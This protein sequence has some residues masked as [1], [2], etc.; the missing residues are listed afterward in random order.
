MQVAKS[1]DSLEAPSLS[2]DTYHYVPNIFLLSKKMTNQKQER[3]RAR[4]STI[5]CP[6]SIITLRNYQNKTMLYIPEPSEAEP[7][8]ELFKELHEQIE[9]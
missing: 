6:L 1:I 4:R 8:H 5:R 3:S 7:D 9:I 2:D